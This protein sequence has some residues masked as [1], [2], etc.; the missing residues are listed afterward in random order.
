[1]GGEPTFVSIDDMEGEQWNSKALGE[2]KLKLSSELLVSLK[3]HFAEDG[4]L[5]YGQGKWYPGE[6]LPRWALGLF[7]RTD[8]KP[9]WHDKSLLDDT[10]SKNKVAKTTA[11]KIINKLTDKLD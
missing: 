6:E 4:L 2:D 8:N 1:M 5:H 3:D 9:L 7:W 10:R 11:Q